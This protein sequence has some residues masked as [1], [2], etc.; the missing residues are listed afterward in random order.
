LN[1]DR[2]QTQGGATVN[3]APGWRME[4]A[5]GPSALFGANGMRFG[6]DGNIYVAQ[7]FGSQI[8]AVNPS[9][10]DTQ[11]V[12]PV[13]GDI[14]APDDLAFDSRGTL[15]ATEVFNE[16]VSARDRNG[17]VRVIAGDL[18]VANGIVIHRDRIFVDEFRVDGRVL[19]LYLDGR[20]PRII[21]SGLTLP[22]ALSLGPDNYLYFPL[23]VNGEIWRVPVEGGTPEKFIDGL[24]VP[25][26][27]KF[28]AKGRLAVTQSG[29]GE[30][31]RYDLQSRVAT[32]LATL[33]IGI[34]NLEFAADGRLYVSNF[35]NGCVTEIGETG[36]LR[37]LVQAGI[38]GPSGLAVAQDG[39][40]YFADGMSYAALSPDGVA[41]RPSMLLIHGFPGFV[42]S[43]ATSRDGGLYFTNSAGGV[44]TFEPGKEA[45]YVAAD[46]DQAMGIVVSP[47]GKAIVCE[48]GAGRVVTIGSKGAS[49]L[50][51]GLARPT[52]IA[53][54][55][56][57]C[58]V[59][60]AGAGRVIRIRNGATET[61]LDGLQEPHGVAQSGQNLFVLDRVA[62]QLW[63]VSLAT[64][65]KSVIASDLAVGSGPS[66]TPKVL[67]GIPGVMPG[68]LLPFA[69][70]AAAADGGVF[71][72]CDAD[73]SI[74]KIRR[75]S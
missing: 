15:Y 18:P 45:Q 62:K 64:R 5:L 2:Y 29:N 25:T 58:Y 16:R 68:P 46:L 54:D 63:Q 33:A 55:G 24:S 75:A 30:V 26:A 73:G 36:A 7:A 28:D 13:G 9:S 4:R 12:S 20:A 71:I 32:R 11:I 3:I 56:S 51:S 37:V 21:A 17:A 53:I 70:L 57:D 10:G 8:T 61:I 60:E 14:V 22:N 43:V 69:D 35:T 49:T 41:V 44:A 6:P 42:R 31:T 66:I 47:E 72:G 74:L 67:P 65:A 1:K 19:E 23:V 50:A 39:T 34:D 40:L 38:V 59:S 52:G 48:A 27:V